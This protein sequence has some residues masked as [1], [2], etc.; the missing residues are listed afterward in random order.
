MGPDVRDARGDRDV[1]GGGK[2]QRAGGKRLAADRLADPD[3]PEAHRLDLDD[4]LSQLGGGKVGHRAEPDAGPAE[5]HARAG[6]RVCCL[7][8]SSICRQA[9]S[10][11]ALCWSNFRSKNEWGAPSYTTWL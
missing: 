9:S 11:A 6:C 3:R 4:R 5:V 10:D 8:K 7:M 1:A 2:D